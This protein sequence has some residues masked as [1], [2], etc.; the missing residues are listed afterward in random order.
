M[1]NSQPTVVDLS[2][3]LT[4]I[5]EEQNP[6]SPH[7]KGVYYRQCVKCLWKKFC[8]TVLILPFRESTDSSAV[9]E[10][11]VPINHNIKTT[12]LRLLLISVHF[13]QSVGF[14][15]LQ[16]KKTHL[17]WKRECAYECRCAI[18]FLPKFCMCPAHLALVWPPSTALQPIQHVESSAHQ[19][20]RETT[21]ALQLR[22]TS[23][24]KKSDIFSIRSQSFF[25]FILHLKLKVLNEECR[26]TDYRHLLV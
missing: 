18:V 14:S 5:N 22:I 1:V 10:K 17:I 24:E 13:N 15:W 4:E 7:P 8:V 11:C 26:D 20:V 12:R 21:L 3:F 2:L 6:V 16:V 23:Q 25:F 19:S 9:K